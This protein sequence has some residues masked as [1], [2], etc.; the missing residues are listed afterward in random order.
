MI[1]LTL[2]GPVPPPY[3][4]MAMQTGQLQRLLTAQTDISVTLIPVNPPYRPAWAGK[5]PVLRALCR[6]VPYL[7]QLRR[8][9]RHTDV[10][11]V[12]ANSGWAWHLFAAPAIW[13]ARYYHKPV[14]VNYRGGLAESFLQ[15]QSRR[16]L[17]VLRRA[18]CI[19]TPSRFLQQ[20][21]SRYQLP[22]QIIPNIIDTAI[23][24]AEHKSYNWQAPHLVV[25]RNLE[26]IYDVATALRAFALIKAAKPRARLT[27]AGSGPELHALQQ[28]TTELQLTDAVTFSGKLNRN[29]IAALYAEADL[30]LNPSTADNMPNS[31]LEALASKVLVVSTDVGGIPFMVNHQQQVLLV[32]PAQP[33]LMADAALLL[34]N[35]P[36]LALTL[37]ENGRQLINQFQP[38][39]VIPDWCQLYHSL[40]ADH[41]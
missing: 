13:I 12:M 9:L 15:Q 33:Q 35:T 39:Q 40:G 23:F 37:A 16:V 11:H 18:S 22:C 14:I 17:P 20:V 19:V 21:F 41:A 8:N 38:E 24:N 3:G 6:L 10:V 2:I 4:G 27:I 25:T 5:L 31:L 30:M 7:W 26:A 1:R 29:Q 28:L 36:Q 34:L 32:L